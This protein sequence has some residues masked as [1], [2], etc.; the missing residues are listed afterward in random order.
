MIMRLTNQ[1]PHSFMKSPRLLLTLICFVCFGTIANATAHTWQ[2]RSPTPTTN[3]MNSFAYGNGRFVGVG[4]HGDV[5]TSPDGTVWT[6]HSSGVAGTLARVVFD[7]RQ[8]VAVGHVD[9]SSAGLILRSADGNAWSSQTT[10]NWL[11]D[12]AYGNGTYVAVAQLPGLDALHQFVT[13]TDAV[14]WTTRTPPCNVQRVL[15]AGGR[16]VGPDAG[17]QVALSSDGISWTLGTVPAGASEALSGAAATTDQFLLCYS[18]PHAFT[19]NDGVTWSDVTGTTSVPWNPALPIPRVGWPGMIGA[20]AGKFF[21][22]QGSS[23]PDL[24]WSAGRNWSDTPA[25]GLDY[26]TLCWGGGVF[27]ATEIEFY[28]T[29]YANQHSHTI[30]TSTDA[31]TWTSRTT[32]PLFDSPRMVPVVFGLGRFFA[33]RNVSPD[34]V[35]WSA[36][37]G[38]FEPTHAT[39]DRLFRVVAGT[40][41]D[42]VSMSA[43][44]VTATPVDVKMAHPVAVASG[45]GVYVWVGRAGAIA[46]STD[47]STWTARTSTTSRNLTA[48]TFAF[49]RFVAVGDGGTLLTSP[50]G[51]LWT[52]QADSTLA[53]F[54]LKAV[55]AGSDR[56]VLGAVTSGEASTVTTA[57]A[58]GTVVKV[59]AHAGLAW[60]IHFDGEYVAAGASSIYELAPPMWRLRSNDGET[61]DA[62]ATSTPDLQWITAAVGN[63]TAVF[64]GWTAR[65]DE[66]YKRRTFTL[67]ALTGPAATTVP[68][69]PFPPTAQT[70]PAGETV[71]FTA[72][73]SGVGPFTYQWFHDGVAIAGAT[74]SV[75]QLSSAEAPAAG[76]YTVAITNSIGSVTSA[77]A[78]LTITPAVP[79]AITE[80][81]ADAEVANYAPAILRVT[82]TGSGPITYQW[83]KDGRPIEGATGAT[84][85][86]GARPSWT[87]QAVGAFDVVVSAPHSTVTSR[88]AHVTWGGM[89][90]ELQT[91]PNIRVPVGGSLKVSV[92]VTGAHPPFTY[93]WAHQGGRDVPDATS[94][95][96]T[97]ANI[98]PADA[99]SY[100][101][102]VTD[103]AGHHEYAN[104]QLI[105]APDASNRITITSQPSA[106]GNPP[107]LTVAATGAT[108]YQWR[109]DGQPIPNATAATLVA[110]APG[111]YD[112]L[113]YTVDGA[114]LISQPVIVAGGDSRLVNLSALGFAGD[115]EETLVQGFV[116]QGDARFS[117]ITPLLRSVGPGL[118]PLKVEGALPD[119]QLRVLSA[120]GS[121][122]ALNDNWSAPDPFGVTGAAIPADMAA[123]GAF[124]LTAG[125]LDSALQLRTIAP[126]RYTVHASD[127]QGRSGRVLNEIYFD[128]PTLQLTNLS[129]R[130]RVGPGGEV[131]IAG[132][133]IRGYAPLQIL[134]RAVGPGLAGSGITHPLANPKLTLMNAAGTVL[135]NNDNWGQAE[136]LAA[137]TA[138]IAKAGAAPLAPGSNDAAMLV[139]L[140]PGVY[141]VHASSVDGSAGIALVE[142]YDLR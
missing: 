138:A 126:G 58:D 103:A 45:A 65:P 11:I 12:L 101:V 83:R 44:G 123:R 31:A 117:E 93:Q 36:W 139:Q 77:A 60:L 78:V 116:L 15:F 2:F 120:S 48:I 140:A 79:L 122:I 109:L 7:G 53:A 22:Y 108:S 76:S 66:F 131:L 85:S 89:A 29:S 70:V 10:S 141:T 4:E 64:A 121:V 3:R 50:D 23:L 55:A 38:T 40:T 74:A 88:Q 119:P 5:V 98:A 111:V 133:V 112:V 19:S 107:T 8:F 86:I 63:G 1:R 71:V 128:H 28:S 68:G 41:A 99:D 80:Q 27:V 14:T 106:T 105:V 59:Y 20:A 18:G 82:V 114:A 13:S 42:S 49:N 129:V 96:F 97:L 95:T 35:A 17:R 33:G 134:V 110:P 9:G 21:V 25:T 104:F 125:S 51:V 92:A 94:A 130:A 132:F 16:F 37:P 61:W 46:S 72:G 6:E 102:T 24:Q 32:W 75:L 26:R 90:V 136:N 52:A 137:L 54:D 87:D 30:W 81:P 127:V 73:A 124:P 91:I 118:L 34:G 115:G 39:S 67:L 113:L 84:L 62:P 69:I 57:L 135:H 100:A 56:L 43:D 47:G 142:L